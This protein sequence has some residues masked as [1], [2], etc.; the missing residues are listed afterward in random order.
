MYP[1]P[2]L[3]IDGHISILPL[4]TKTVAF[5]ARWAWIVMSKSCRRLN[6]R[7]AP[8]RFHSPR[9]HGD[10]KCRFLPQTSKLG[11][12]IRIQRQLLFN[13][14][15]LK[16]RPKRWVMGLPLAWRAAR[17]AC[18]SC[19]AWASAKNRHR[20]LPVQSRHQAQAG[21][22]AARRP[23]DGRCARS[24]Q[25]NHSCDWFKDE[26]RELGVA[27]GFPSAWPIATPSPA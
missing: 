24:T 18:V 23:A 7:I 10:R 13:W 21:P 6:G 12:G 26:V 16:C 14:R 4:T 17:R 11:H 2:R 19:G 22:V 9:L 27:L 20:E 3:V 8:R 25:T 5:Q 15:L 1:P